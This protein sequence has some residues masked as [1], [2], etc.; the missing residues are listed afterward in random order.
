MNSQQAD[1]RDVVPAVSRLIE[2]LGVGW[3][4]ALIAEITIISSCQVSARRRR[5]AC[6]IFE[7][8]NARYKRSGAK[9]ARGTERGSRGRRWICDGTP[10]RQTEAPA[11]ITGVN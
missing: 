9:A 8:C 2:Q 3:L 5:N 6:A 11:A 10:A 7:Y 4:V 1:E